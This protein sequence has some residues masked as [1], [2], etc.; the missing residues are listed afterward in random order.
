MKRV[1]II[2]LSIFALIT[3]T[4]VTSNYIEKRNLETTNDFYNTAFLISTN[5]YVRVYS[6]PLKTSLDDVN[7]YKNDIEG[8]Y[9]KYKNLKTTKETLEGEA[10]LDNLFKITFEIIKDCEEILSSNQYMDNNDVVNK[11][12]EAEKYYL[13]LEAVIN[14]N[15]IK[16]SRDVKAEAINLFLKRW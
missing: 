13:E 1:S 9:E 3:I 6:L 5:T 12:F 16:I 8:F 11:S 4:I 15:G 14:K 10:A 2:I 7:S